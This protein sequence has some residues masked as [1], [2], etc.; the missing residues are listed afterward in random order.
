MAKASDFIIAIDDGHGSATPGKRT[1]FIASLGRQVRENEFNKPVANFLEAELK[2]CGFRTIQLAPTDYDT[3][4]KQRTDT[5]NKAKADALVSAHFNALDGNFSAPTPQ[6][7]SAHIH[8][9]STEGRKLANAILRHLAQGT[10]Q[11]NRG[12]VE[13]NLHMT[14]ESNM[15]AVLVEF[16]FM[17]YEREAL[18]MLN[19]AFQRECAREVAKGI[20]DYFGVTYVAESTKPASKPEVTKPK[21]K[22]VTKPEE[23]PLTPTQEATRQEAMRLGITDGKNPRSTPNNHY[24]WSALIPLAQRVEALENALEEKNK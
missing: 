4:L 10:S 5:A 13:Q 16:G 7:F 12:I 19:E 17:D 22:S 1:P 11:Q 14:R 6:G 15:P 8:P 18:L 24:L 21:P 9:G 3:P 20:C 2:R 23:H